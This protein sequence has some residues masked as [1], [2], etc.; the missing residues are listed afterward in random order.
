M[1]RIKEETDSKFEQWPSTQFALRIVFF[2]TQRRNN[3]L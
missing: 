3:V 2:V 1:W